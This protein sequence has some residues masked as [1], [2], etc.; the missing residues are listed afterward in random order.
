MTS[1]THPSTAEAQVLAALDPT[2]IARDVGRVVAVPSL[3]GDERGAVELLAGLTD[4]YGLEARVDVHD[5]DALRAAPGY[6]GEEADRAELV[7]L[8]AV[9]PGTGR[10]RLCLNG[11][12]D[13]VGPGTQAWARPPF[14]GEVAGGHVHGRGAVDMKGGVIAAVHAMAA[15][16]RVLGAA[17]GE[18]VLQAVPSEEDG[19][20][21]T[22]AA[23]E[24][25]ARFDACLIPEPTAFKVVAAHGGALTFTGLVRGTSA[26]AAVRLE[27][28]SAVDRYLPIHAALAAHEAH[29]NAHVDHPLMR[30]LTLPYPLL[31]GR[32]AAGTWSSQVPDELRFE[33]R[34]GV[35]VGQGV[36]DARAG[37][38]AAVAAATDHRGPPVEIRWHGGQFEPSETPP[39]D[40]FVG[41]VQTAARDELGDTPRLA[42]V[43]Y[44]ADMRMYRRHGIPTVMFGTPGLEWAHAVDERVSVDALLSLA[45]TI[46]RV[47]VRFG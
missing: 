13:V 4:A 11:H 14:A 29:V 9:L 18:V 16:R 31:V 22:F 45:R 40:P 3:T 46:A 36:D 43:P 34:V 42:G 35:R 17:P 7:G 19:G 33:G 27:G 6:P 38:E 10:R 2:A 1:T 47:I 32:L 30:D 8:T 24:A 28:C 26:H 21:G 44:G 12:V 20:L 15:V 37:F 5:L 23:L 41:L 25:D 39:D